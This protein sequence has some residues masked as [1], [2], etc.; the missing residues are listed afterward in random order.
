[1]FNRLIA[2]GDSWTAGH[3]VEKD[4][5]YKE[6]IDCGPFIN[7]VRQNNGWPRHLSQY[8]DIPFVNFGVCNHSNPDIIS[9]INRYKPYL[10]DSSDLIII[11]LSYPLRR[12]NSPE[13]VVRQIQKELEGYT[14][15]L[16]NS[17]SLT[18]LPEMDH[19]LKGIDL[20]KF[21]RKDEHFASML[22][23]YERDQDVSVWE[24][25]FRYPETWQNMPQ[26]DTHPNYLGY[27]LIAK[28]IY[29]DLLTRV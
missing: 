15:F 20:S 22:M 3:G 12:S 13:H 21:P 23:K 19:D 11:M 16:Y 27:K 18:F 2:F 28:A 1:M 7:Q 9:D 29:T 8:Y 26:G 25:D 4:E 6:I 5:Q 10:D 17:F 14:Y 24:Y